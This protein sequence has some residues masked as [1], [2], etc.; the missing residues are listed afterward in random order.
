MHALYVLFESFRCFG[1]FLLPLFAFVLKSLSF[2]SL[3]FW[4][5]ISCFLSNYVGHFFLPSCV[6]CDFVFAP[7]AV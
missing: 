3:A 4:T 5:C 1:M 7:L 6:Q 2:L